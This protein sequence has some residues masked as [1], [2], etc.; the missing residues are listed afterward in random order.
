MSEQEF[1][2]LLRRDR[3]TFIVKGRFT[4][5][6][7]PSHTNPKPRQWNR[8]LKDGLVASVA[9]ILVGGSVVYTNALS[10]KGHSPKITTG[11]SA[12][13]LPSPVIKQMVDFVLPVK[14]SFPVY[15][16]V[17]GLGAKDY[18][19]KA[20]ST[21]PSFSMFSVQ[22][23]A[24]I[25]ISEYKNVSD[26]AISSISWTSILD[27]ESGVRYWKHVLNQHSVQYYFKEGSTVIFVEQTTSEKPTFPAQLITSLKPLYLFASSTN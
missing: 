3:E 14:Y 12:N 13:Q 4:A 7:R 20:M 23:A 9:I 11:A 27:K 15:I 5:L 6:K 24:W 26:P 10:H 19:I 2:D 16:P 8:L 22:K 1:D 17:G 25:T 18:Q 21:Q